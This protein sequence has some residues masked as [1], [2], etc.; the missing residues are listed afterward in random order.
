MLQDGLSGRVENHEHESGRDE[1]GD[2]KVENQEE[3]ADAAARS[4]LFV[5]LG[6]HVILERR[7]QHLINTRINTN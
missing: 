2:Q 4:V 7:K 5:I 3:G 6:R 1:T